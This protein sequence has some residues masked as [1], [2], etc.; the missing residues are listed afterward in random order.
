MANKRS[1]KFMCGW[2]DR[3]DTVVGASIPDIYR[4]ARKKGWVGGTLRNEACPDCTKQ[5]REE[6]REDGADAKS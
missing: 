3:S 1:I 6:R 5:M 2:C 4:K